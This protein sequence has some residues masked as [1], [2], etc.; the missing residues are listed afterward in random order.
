MNAGQTGAGL[1]G[2]LAELRDLQ[3]Q[4]DILR[5]MRRETIAFGYTAF[6]VMRLPVATSL[7]LAENSVITS[8]P[9]QFLSAF[10]RANLLGSSP[11][12]ARLRRSTVPFTFSRED[13]VSER[14]GEDARH[15]AAVYTEL[16]YSS[17][18]CVPVHDPEGRRSAVIFAGDRPAIEAEELA[19]LTMIAIHAHQRLTGVA[20][21]HERPEQPLTEREIACLTWT[22]AGKT[23]ADIASILSLSEHTVNHYLNRA[24]K[25]LDTVNRTQA[26]AKAL[27][28]GLIP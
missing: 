23:S 4:F 15:A 12:V 3:S 8:L 7:T 20:G 21:M 25:K 19:R 27:R 28:R 13:L 18:V 24:A 16:A 1:A 17:G 10:D 22:A 9:A 26:V 6:L 2:T 11:L 5:L 14:Q